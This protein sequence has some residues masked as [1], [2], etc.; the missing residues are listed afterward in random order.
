M[1]TTASHGRVKL[2][3]MV[4]NEPPNRE[5]EIFEQALDIVSPDV[6]A[7]FL[8]GACGAD[9]QL[10]QRVEA[11][12]AAHDATGFLPDLLRRARRQRE[13]VLASSAASGRDYIHADDAIAGLIAIA[14]G[15]VDQA[16]LPGVRTLVTFYLPKM[17]LDSGAWANVSFVP[18]AKATIMGLRRGEVQTY[19][20]D[21]AADPLSFNR[22]MFFD[23]EGRHM[24]V[25]EVAR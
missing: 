24:R 18:E 21:V 23:R 3:S 14:Q 2:K 16:P 11:L 20:T 12:L 6:R 9:A 8:K 17:G 13:I 7:G 19:A 4:T 22:G 10:R 5:K 15:I 1:A 25:D